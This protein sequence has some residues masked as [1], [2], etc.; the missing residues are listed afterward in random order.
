MCVFLGWGDHFLSLKSTYQIFAPYH[1]FS[2]LKSSWLVVDGGGGGWVV[3]SRFSVQ[4]KTKLNNYGICRGLA[5]FKSICTI[6]NKSEL[7]GHRNIKIR[8]RS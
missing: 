7:I 3:E 4:L 8:V 1:A 2:P 6:L 5:H